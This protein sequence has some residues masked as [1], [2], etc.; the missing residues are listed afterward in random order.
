MGGVPKGLEQVGSA[1]IIDRVADTLSRACGRVILAANDPGAGQWL[2]GVELVEDVHPGTGGLAGVEAA[3]RHVGDSVVVA[4]DMPFVPAP[5]VEDIVRRS[6]AGRADVVIPES[7]SPYGFEPFC[8]FYSARLL[9]RLNAFLVAGGGA[10][11]DFLAAETRVERIALRDVRAFGDP[12][13][14]FFSVNTADDLARARTVAGV[15]G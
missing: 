7:D 10:A 3:L 8:A 2:K 14:M 6:I 4:W 5:L 1:R 15:A 11:R 13:T 9:P 12:T